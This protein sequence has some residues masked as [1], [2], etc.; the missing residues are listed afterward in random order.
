MDVQWA[1]DSGKQ[2][3]TLVSVGADGKVLNW[4]LGNRLRF[5]IKG[6]LLSKPGVV[7]KSSR[8]EYPLTYGATSISLSGG[9]WDVPGS[10]LSRRPK[11]VLVGQEGGAIVRGQAKRAL[12]L[13]GRGL[14]RDDFKVLP[15]H[16][17]LL[18]PLP[19]L[20]LLVLSSSDPHLHLHH[21]LYLHL[22]S[23]PRLLFALV[24]SCMHLS[25]DLRRAKGSSTHHT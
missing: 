2:E 13:Q 4:D 17:S 14:G 21:Y 11:W 5:P 15:L 12:V 16:L 25:R 19:L 10:S 23:Y 6:S 22:H 24:R 3:W 20:I 18:L 7:G 1:Y 9:T 8:K